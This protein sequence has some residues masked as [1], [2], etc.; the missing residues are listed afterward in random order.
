MKVLD[1]CRIEAIVL[2]AV[3][4][5]HINDHYLYGLEKGTELALVELTKPSPGL[6]SFIA[7]AIT[8]LS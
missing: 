8:I 7:S 2:G 4:E 1:Q 5:I 3:A 6:R